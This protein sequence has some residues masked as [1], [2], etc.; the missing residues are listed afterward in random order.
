MKI[1]PVNRLP[2]RLGNLL[3]GMKTLKSL[4][5]LLLFSIVLLTQA[6]HSLWAMASRPNPDPSAPPPPAWVQWFPILFMV[7]VFYFLLI[8]P[9]SKQRKERENL[10]SNIKKGDRIVTQG[11]LIVTV[12]NVS[13]DVLDI[14]LNDET[15]AK[16]KRS[17]VQ[18]VLKPETPV[19]EPVLVEK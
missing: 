6:N 4:S 18:E 13:A 17:G 7:V 10:L 5:N 11:G 9:Q 16:L 19:I 3:A 14:K 1:S 15:K 12:V 8:R 2:C